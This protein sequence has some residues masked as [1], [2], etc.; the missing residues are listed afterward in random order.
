MEFKMDEK[1]REIYRG[2]FDKW[3]ATAQVDMMIEEMAE[4]TQA[5]CKVKRVPESST[6]AYAVNEEIADV[7]IMLEQMMFFFHSEE[8]V[9]KIKQEKLTRLVTRLEARV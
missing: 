2:C 9:L 4:L 1:E 6:R 3:G 5:L 8:I 7:T